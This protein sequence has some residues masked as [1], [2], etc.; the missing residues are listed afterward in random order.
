MKLSLNITDFS[1]PAGT[2]AQRLTEVVEAAE[3]AGIDTVWVGDHLIMVVPGASIDD[4]ML[5]AY[6]T[7]GYLAARTTRVRLGTMVAGVTFR[8]PALLVK[9][10][11]T[12]D[13]LSG[14]RAWLGIGAGYQQMEA[15]AM[16]LD[17]PPTTERF[18]RLEETL[19]IADRMWSGDQSP[20]EGRHYRLGRPVGSPLPISR[21]RILIGGT[22]EKRTLRLVAEYGDACN[23]FDIPG[24]L[25]HK[26]AVL[27]KHCEAVG[28]PYDAIEKTVSARL[29]GTA[30]AL[31]PKLREFHDLGIDHT[32]LITEGPWTPDRVASL[33]PLTQL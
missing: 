31:V 6:T 21:P 27:A 7:L 23:L 17:L 11:T 5:E 18:E 26:L 4:P 2:I 8:P 20:F 33:T 10:V 29:E 22:G 12:V 24:Q 15:D 32:I 14:G 28:R 19:R 13:A 30:D 3:A 9:A 16:G 25:P 1:Y